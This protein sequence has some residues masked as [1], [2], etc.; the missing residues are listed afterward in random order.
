MKWQAMPIEKLMKLKTNAQ[1]DF[2]R[3][4]LTLSNKT[5]GGVLPTLVQSCS[6]FFCKLLPENYEK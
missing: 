3:Q 1:R 2:L 5:S 4:L 6:S